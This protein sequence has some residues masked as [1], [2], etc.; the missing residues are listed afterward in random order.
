MTDDT[1]RV[2]EKFYQESVIGGLEKEVR[3]IGINAMDGLRERS[4][5]ASGHFRNNWNP[6]IESTDLSVKDKPPEGQ[7]LPAPAPG[8]GSDKFDNY[9]AGQTLYITNNLPYAERLNSG[10]SEQA[11]DPFVDEVVLLSIKNVSAL[12]KSGRL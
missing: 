7:T 12:S 11:P 8:E 1:R 3:L 10:W 9:K 5:V 2:F 4:P 6:S